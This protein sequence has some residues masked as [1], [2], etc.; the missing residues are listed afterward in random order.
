MTNREFLNAIISGSTI[1]AELVE[2][3]TAELAK[4]DAANVKRKNKPS[5]TALE[6]A[7]VLKA[8]T[9]ALTDVPQTAAELAAIAGVSTQKASALLR[10][11]VAAGVASVTDVKHA[12]KGVCKG[13]TIAA[14][15]ETEATEVAA[16]A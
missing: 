7:P 13:Y 15:T 3:A 14:E 5:K 4:L 9:E 8:L 1:T 2:H 10:Q 12:K 11:L 6:N 16:E